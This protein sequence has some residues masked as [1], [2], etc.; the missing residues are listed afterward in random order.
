M[1]MSRLG[2]DLQTFRY[3]CNMHC[4]ILAW[5]KAKPTFPFEMIPLQVYQDLTVAPSSR[6]LGP[7]LDLLVLPVILPLESPLTELWWVAIVEQAKHL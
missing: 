6:I 3:R 2:H 4:H 7:L 5:C 1:N